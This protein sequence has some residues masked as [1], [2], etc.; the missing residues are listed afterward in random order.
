[1]SENSKG[2]FS[3][4]V[5]DELMEVYP[6]TRH[7][8]IA[9]IAIMAALLGVR[10]SEEKGVYR[11]NTDSPQ[12]TKKFFTLL[13]KTIN[14]S[15][16]DGVIDADRKA[17]IEELLKC[18]LDECASGVNGLLLQ[19]ECCCKAF[20]RGAFLAAGTVSDPNKSYHLEIAADN[21]RIAGQIC[22]VF[23]TLG[24][25]ARHTRRKTHHVVYI[26]ES[27]ALVEV[28]GFMGAPLSLME[29]ENIRIV[30]D[31]RNNLNRTVNCETA[32]IKKT[33]DAALTQVKDIDYIDRVCGLDELPKGLREMAR[34]RRRFPEATLTEL[35]SMASPPVG[36]SGVNHRLRRISQYADELR[37]E[38]H[39]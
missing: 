13:D 29:L 30:K 8:R 38:G 2:K 39:I 32:N 3:K 5:K 23:G 18:S 21:E 10:E 11:L 9:E 22:D 28:L 15:K 27:T 35:G 20:I 24:V 1:M 33:I 16:Y 26:K 36:K 6:Q 4:N 19:H 25:F 12:L 17:K 37:R 34:L 14:I 7:C 31:I